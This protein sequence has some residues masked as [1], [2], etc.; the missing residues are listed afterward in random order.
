MS[1]H[2]VDPVVN[3]GAVC[4]MQ[5]LDSCSINIYYGVDIIFTCA[6]MRALKAVS[7]RSQKLTTVPL[8][9]IR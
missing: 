7:A 5:E 2:G 6:T 9:P 8:C 4:R 3:I 1:S